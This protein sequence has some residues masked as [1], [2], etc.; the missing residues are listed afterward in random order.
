MIPAFLPP[1][2]CFAHAT[3]LAAGDDRSRCSCCKWP[4]A[5]RPMAGTCRQQPCHTSHNSARPISFR[6]S[7]SRNDFAFFFA[8]AASLAPAENRQVIFR[9][10]PLY[11]ASHSRRHRTRRRRARSRR[12]VRN[13]GRLAGKS[14]VD[15]AQDRCSLADDKL[16]TQRDLH[17]VPT[18]DERMLFDTTRPY[19]RDAAWLLEQPHTKRAFDLSSAYSRDRRT[20]RRMG[21]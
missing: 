16:W 17:T 4:A 19:H 5:S 2:C 11:L 3:F 1:R 10:P 13:D 12:H 15:R 20:R 6:E 7:I 21:P 9:T 8:S 18:A 14:T